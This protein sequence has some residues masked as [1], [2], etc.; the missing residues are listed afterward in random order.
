MWIKK[1]SISIN[2]LDFITFKQN[3]DAI[4]KTQR[5]VDNWPDVPSS[6]NLNSSSLLPLIEKDLV[7]IINQENDESSNEKC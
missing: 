5:G 1:T 6:E 2:D 4:S 3:P 7:D